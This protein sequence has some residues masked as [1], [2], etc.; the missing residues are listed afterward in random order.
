MDDEK[1]PT[2]IKNFLQALEAQDPARVISFFAEDGA[3]VAP[4]GTFRGKQS[5]R[6]YLGWQFGRATDIKVTVGGNGIISR[7]NQA[8]V[9][10]VISGTLKGARFQYLAFCAYEFMEGQIREVRT[11]YDRLSL[12]EQ[13]AG[14][15][16]ASG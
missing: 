10:H 8:F 6:G 5:V 2:I 3:W 13:G 9:E 15:W 16:L 11:V 14:G 4:E 12:A 1:V 7:G